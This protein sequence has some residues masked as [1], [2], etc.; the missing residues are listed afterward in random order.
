MELEKR[1]ISGIYFRYK[2]EKGEFE[3]RVFEDLPDADQ[4][5]IVNGRDNDYLKSL[6][7]MLA[8]RLREVADE[9]DIMVD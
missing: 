7:K 5:K 6:A 3:N 2:N 8:K 4:D 9:F 1:N